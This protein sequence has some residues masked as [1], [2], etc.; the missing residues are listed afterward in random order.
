MLELYVWEVQSV[1]MIWDGMS[2][3]WLEDHVCINRWGKIRF[4]CLQQTNL[5]FNPFMLNAALFFTFYRFN[6]VW[7]VS[8][9]CCGMCS[10]GSVPAFCEAYL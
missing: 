10:G 1:V 6:F 9:K 4:C 3:D 5:V 2:N 8:I 7:Y